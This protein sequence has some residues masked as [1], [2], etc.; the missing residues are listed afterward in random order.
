LILFWSDISAVE[1]KKLCYQK[2]QRLRFAK[3]RQIK[4]DLYDQVIG[5]FIKI[6]QDENSAEFKCISSPGGDSVMTRMMILENSVFIGIHG[7]KGG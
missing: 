3:K 4:I 2:S 5:M 1:S 7:E 6:D